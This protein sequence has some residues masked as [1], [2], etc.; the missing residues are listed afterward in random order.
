MPPVVIDNPILNSPVPRS[1]RGTSGSTRTT[2]S[3][4]S[5]DAGR[6]GSSYFLP[7]AAPK[8][9]AAPGLFDDALPRRRRPRAATSTAS[10]SCVKQ[11]RDRG[12][13]GR[14]PGHPRPARTLARGG[15]LP[16]AVLL[17]GRGAGDAHLHHRGGQADQVRRRLDREV[18]PGEGGRGGDRPVPRRL[19]DGD[20]QRQD[21]R[22]VH[23]HRLAGAQQAPLPARQP[24]HRRLPRRRPRHHHPR[25]A[26]R[27]AA[28][29]TRT[30]T[31]GN[32]TSS[33]PSTAATWAR[34][35][36]V[37]TNFHAFKLREKG[38]AGGL[39]KRVLTANTPGRVHRDRPTRW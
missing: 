19:Q 16:P 6:R 20:R 2:R 27:P 9:K 10:G 30:T 31:T 38:D 4:T 28:R 35:R 11:W 29:P 39:T 8:K 24:V 21:G 33:R 26:P 7:I 12:L 3:P 34:R 18:P 32:S 1:R 23:A 13:A 15:P 14:H 37:V 22:H 5:I 17:P 36:I 25:P